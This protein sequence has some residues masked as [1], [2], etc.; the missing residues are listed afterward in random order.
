MIICKKKILGIEEHNWLYGDI[1]EF[2]REIRGET[3]YGVYENNGLIL[4]DIET[5]LKP[6]YYYYRD[7][8]IKYNWSTEKSVNAKIGLKYLHDYYL[9]YDNER[10]WYDDYDKSNWLYNSSA[11]EMTIPRFLEHNFYYEYTPWSIADGGNPHT[12][13]F[14]TKIHPVFYL[15]SDVKIKE[16]TDGTKANPYILEI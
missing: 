11:N 10:N 5:G 15:S 7:D 4:Y 6:A 12:Y 8:Y 3:A 9:A 14:N 2:N 1:G 13:S 16:G